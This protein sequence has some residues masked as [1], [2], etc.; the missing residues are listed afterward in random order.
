[1]SELITKDTRTDWRGGPRTSLHGRPG[2]RRT[3]Y[4]TLAAIEYRRVLRT[5]LAARA[6]TRL[7]MF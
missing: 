1:M 7:R 2:G 6:E 5:V 3:D 4:N